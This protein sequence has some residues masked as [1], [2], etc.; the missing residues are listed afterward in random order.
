MISY[1]LKCAV[2]NFKEE[3]EHFGSGGGVS[4]RVRVW[5]VLGISVWSFTPSAVSQRIV[6]E[7]DGAATQAERNLVDPVPE[8]LHSVSKLKHYCTRLEMV[9]TVH[10]S[11]RLC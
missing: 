4:S 11:D 5:S 9:Q 2:E 6:V 8:M 10:T 3:F 7:V 1:I